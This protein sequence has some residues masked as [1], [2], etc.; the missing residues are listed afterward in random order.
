MEKQESRIVFG[1][2]ISGI[3]K[4]KRLTQAK[5]S[6]RAGKAAVYISAV[7]TGR[8]NPTLDTILRIAEALEVEPA[9]IFY[10]AFSSEPKE[11]KAL[12]K[13]FDEVIRKLDKSGQQVLMKIVR[14][15][16]DR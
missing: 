14:A 16:A 5:L 1:R 6:K 2:T 12:K 7:E 9:D 15:M 11:I 4:L 3:R 8:I 13:E 10:L